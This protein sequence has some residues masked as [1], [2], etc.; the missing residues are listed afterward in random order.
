MAHEIL[1]WTKSE[2]IDGQMIVTAVDYSGNNLKFIGDPNVVVEPFKTD[3]GTIID[4]SPEEIVIKTGKL[5][6]AV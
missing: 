1:G 3:D 4:F 5:V 2:I 6:A